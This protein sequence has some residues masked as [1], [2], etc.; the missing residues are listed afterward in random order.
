MLSGWCT[1]GKDLMAD[2]LVKHKGF[3][4][5]AMAD[6]LKQ[7]VSKKYNI[8][9]NLTLT[10][11]GKQSFVHTQDKTVRQLL[12]NESLLQKDMYGDDVF[13]S[14]ITNKINSIDASTNIVISDFRYPNEYNYMHKIMQ[15]D[16]CK[17]S[18]KII[19][20]RINRY[21]NPPVKSPSE[22]QLNDFNFDYTIEN[23]KTISYFYDEIEKVLMKSIF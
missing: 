10:Q 8:D 17:T 23:K 12:I 6:E 19:T 9:Y 13:I 21:D 14:Y 15:N 3:R 2:Y 18:N 1:S 5:F 20:I 11:D 7:L 22:I 4:K 16:S